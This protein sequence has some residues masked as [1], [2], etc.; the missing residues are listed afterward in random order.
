MYRQ[1][2]RS[3]PVS[4]AIQTM[5]NHVEVLQATQTSRVAECQLR[6]L[7]VFVSLY[8]ISGMNGLQGMHTHR[9]GAACLSLVLLLTA[10]CQLVIRDCDPAGQ[11]AQAR[12]GPANGPLLPTR[13]LR[14]AF[15]LRL[16]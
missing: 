14:P 5:S 16:L 15:R 2:K 3:S 1:F 10:G 6:E 12:S 9:A 7:P 11:F 8:N 13:C 4:A